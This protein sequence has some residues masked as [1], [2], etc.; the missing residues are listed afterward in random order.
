MAKPEQTAP[1]QSQPEQVKKTLAYYHDLVAK[2]PK[3][4][5]FSI[6]AHLKLGKLY[7]QLG[8]RDAALNEYVAAA[9]QYTHTGE[10]VKALA[11]HQL[12]KYLVAPEA[13]EIPPE[14]TSVYFHQ[15]QPDRA[16][17]PP[18]AWTESDRAD[19]Q[20]VIYTLET[21]PYDEQTTLMNGDDYEEGEIATHLKQNPMFRCLSWAERQW[22]EEHVRIS[23]F[24]EGEIILPKQHNGEWLYVIME[25][26]VSI[27][28]QERALA[29][30]APQDFFGEIAVLLDHPSGTTVSAQSRECSIIEIPKAALMTLI[31][32]HP[33]IAEM[34]RETSRRRMLDTKLANVSL[35]Q[36]LNTTERQ[37]I[38]KFLSPV[39]FRE[40]A[41]II[42]EGDVGDC[43][44][45]IKS[46]TVQVYTYLLMEQN[47][48]K[49]VERDYEQLLLATL[50]DGDFFGEQALISN[51]RRNATVVAATDA[52]LLRFARPDLEVIIRHYP[53]V[54][55]LL[56]RYHH[57]RTTDTL[58]SL[59]AAFQRMMS[60]YAP[61][62]ESQD[63]SNP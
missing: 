25:G 1:P 35:F 44:Y 59:H 30:L 5:P 55:E 16:E 48:G 41:T 10:L 39:E 17:A 9:M 58:E 20:A 27:T 50:S 34:L 29:T 52:Q 49:L 6:N 47:I 11:V 21:L 38:A 8:E 32:K 7:T 36:H 62:A 3:A 33:S 46:G 56:K 53:R 26:R 43:M 37:Q 31:K 19:E 54:A 18:E 45:L 22:L 15:S 57:Q 24:S 28:T 42:A 63:A 61:P 60:Y 2:M 40:G 51:E 13:G 12:I 23:F 4:S 14:L